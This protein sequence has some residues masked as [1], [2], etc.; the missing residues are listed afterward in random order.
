MLK[1]AMLVSALAISAPALAQDKPA[2][3][4]EPTTAA[5]TPP[6]ADPQTTANPAMPTAQ[7]APMTST[8]P[9]TAPADTAQAAPQTIPGQPVTTPAQ[10]AQSTTPATPADPA[11]PA[12]TAAMPASPATPAEGAAATGATQ[13]AQVV[14]TEFPTYDKNSDT[15][16]DKKEFGAWMVA[17]K[18]ASDPSTKAT[19]PATVKWV[20]GAFAS[21]DTDKSGA[22]SKGELTNYLS[23][24]A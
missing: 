10:T 1:T 12:E 18:T 21:A 9:Q 13:V 7:A 3:K 6:A 17:L 16:L 14:D 11:M 8:T 24:G 19:D 4:D 20:S 5:Q 23:Q 22:V 15:N 2:P